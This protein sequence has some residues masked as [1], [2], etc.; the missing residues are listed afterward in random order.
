MYSRI[1]LIDDLTRPDHY[2]LTKQ[3]QCYYLGEY[4]ARMGPRYSQTNQLIYNFKKSVLKRGQ[5]GFHY[6][7]RAIENVAHYLHNLFT[8][9]EL[10]TFIPIPPSKTR[11]HPEYDDRLVQVLTQ[12]R[13]LNNNV[14][15]RDIIIQTQSTEP[16]HNSDDR[17]SPN[18]LLN[19][20][21]IDFS[22]ANGIRNNIFIFDDM[23]TT[24]SHFK[25]VQQILLNNINNINVFGIFIARR[26]PEAIDW[27]FE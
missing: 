6:K 21:Q 23:L 2:Y 16:S 20:Y 9:P 1:S 3:D 17:L 12:Y 24:G 22:A 14:D 26:A 27:D 4:T 13:A 19:L 5:Q 25:A 7:G 15:F 11:T 18:E 8:R 10:V